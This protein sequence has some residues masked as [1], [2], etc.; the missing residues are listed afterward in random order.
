MEETGWVAKGGEKI[1]RISGGN[2]LGGIFESLK[3]RLIFGDFRFVGHG[4]YLPFSG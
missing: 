3:K 2:N 1:V 4:D